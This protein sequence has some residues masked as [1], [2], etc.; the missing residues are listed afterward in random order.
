[1]LIH[2]SA[3]EE[4]YGEMSRLPGFIDCSAKETGN[5][6]CRAQVVHLTSICNRKAQMRT[7]TVGWTINGVTTIG[8][9]K[10]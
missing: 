2:H 8:T 4:G 6:G 10:E 9:F 3:R 5:S 1:M 7:A